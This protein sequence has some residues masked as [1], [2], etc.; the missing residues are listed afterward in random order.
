MSYFSGRFQRETSEKQELI[1]RFPV[2]LKQS[3]SSQMRPQETPE[4]L[5]VM[6][7]RTDEVGVDLENVATLHAQQKVQWINVLYK[8]L[9]LG[10]NFL[11]RIVILILI[12]VNFIQV[13]YVYVFLRDSTNSSA[14][15][16]ILICDVLYLIDYGFAVTIYFWK[17]L[18]L[19]LVNPPRNKKTIIC[20][21]FLVLPYS[22]VYETVYKNDSLSTFTILRSISFLRLFHLVRFFQE[23]SSSAGANHWKY[24]IMQYFIYFFLLQHALACIWYLIA[25]PLG[26]TDPGGW[27]LNISRTKRYPK[28]HF[29]WYVVCMYFAL[30]NITN[31]GFG[32]VVPT[33]G[34][35]KLIASKIS[36]T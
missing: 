21:A 30:I 28:S 23:K 33:S 22:L 31:S 15:F 11:W 6:V 1:T 4:W 2:A 13:S 19:R 14:Y 36:N 3:Q 35:E 32:D 18:Q 9:C 17:N 16:S 10:D 29:Q 26:S 7:E 27:T 12:V 25:Y 24:F 20:D 8:I 5:K 34:P